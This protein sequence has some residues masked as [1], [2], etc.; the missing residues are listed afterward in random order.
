MKNIIV[1][2]L[3]L[4]TT[5]QLYSQESNDNNIILA[6]F[7]KGSKSLSIP[8]VKVILYNDG[9]IIYENSKNIEYYK[10][11]RYYIGKDIN[12]K[13][14]I[15]KLVE[16]KLQLNSILD[17]Y[18]IDNLILAKSTILA[19][20]VNK[21]Q[22]V[23]EFYG[24]LN[25]KTTNSEILIC[26]DI[27]K[28]LISYRNSN[29]KLLLPQEIDILFFPKEN[30]EKNH[31]LPKIY[32]KIDKIRD[33][34]IILKIEND[35]IDEAITFI[36]TINAD[37]SFLIESENYYFAGTKLVYQ[38]PSDSDWPFNTDKIDEDKII[39]RYKQIE[40]IFDDMT[41]DTNIDEF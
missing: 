29:F 27:Y 30:I 16:I 23:I 14:K 33:S 19:I 12:F 1:I 2:I 8:V 4:V 26:Q 28:E 7:E 22:K 36:N 32:K 11:K 24:G 35:H 41:D 31:N 6:V 21:I 20:D 9:T 5:N 3:L 17:F 40:L 25:R 13:N 39:D 10:G 38:F 34:F 18:N 37:M 15:I